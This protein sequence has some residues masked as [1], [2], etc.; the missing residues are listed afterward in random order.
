MEEGRPWTGVTEGGRAPAS[1]ALPRVLRAGGHA[2]RQTGLEPQRQ[3][4]TENGWGGGPSGRLLGR[5]L[6]PG[7]A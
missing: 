2:P 3:M 1:A 6:G 5:P 4:E 7:W